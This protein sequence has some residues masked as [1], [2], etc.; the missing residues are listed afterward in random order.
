MLELA[1]KGE[2]PVK[3]SAEGVE[4]TATR[5][6]LLDGDTVTMSGHCEKEGVRIGFG[7]CVGTVLPA[8]PFVPAA[9]DAG[10]AST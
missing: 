1:W 6:F 4:A 2:T 7:Q 5:V 10:A 8:S 3:L 9:A